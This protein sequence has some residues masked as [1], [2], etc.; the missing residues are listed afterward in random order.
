MCSAASA[1]PITKRDSVS[2][3]MKCAHK[4]VW[5]TTFQFPLYLPIQRA[6]SCPSLC[7]ELHCRSMR[8]RSYQCSG[9]LQAQAPLACLSA[10]ELQQSSCIRLQLDSNP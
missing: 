7:H 4:K 10:A 5:Q 3:N 8:D 9:C 1:F 6:L 2:T